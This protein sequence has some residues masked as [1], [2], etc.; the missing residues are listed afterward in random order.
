MDY[1][2]IVIKLIIGMGIYNVWLL[3]SGRAT[4]WRGGDAKNMK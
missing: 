1:V 4:N 3:R 2:M